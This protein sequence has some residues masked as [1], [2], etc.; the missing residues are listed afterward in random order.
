MNILPDGIRQKHLAQGEALPLRGWLSLS[1]PA[2]LLILAMAGLFGGGRSAR[3]TA[4]APSA[5]VTLAMPTTLRSGV[6]FETDVDVLARRDIEDLTIALTAELWRDM[7]IN[8]TLP[9]AGEQD[10]REGQFRFRYG[11]VEAGSRIRIKF[12]GQV[13]PPLIGTNRGEVAVFDGQSRLA[14]IPVAIKVLP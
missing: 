7:T 9:E 10:Y 8:T 12:D 5:H 6:F 1:I 2:A 13:N 4:D 3:L 14:T 11:P